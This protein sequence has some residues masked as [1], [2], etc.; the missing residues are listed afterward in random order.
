MGM[1]GREGSTGTSGGEL[2]AAAA[3]DDDDLVVVGDGDGAGAATPGTRA[4]SH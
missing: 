1:P 2:T 4:A 3:G